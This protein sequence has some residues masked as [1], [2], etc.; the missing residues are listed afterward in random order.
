MVGRQFAL[1]DGAMLAMNLTQLCGRSPDVF[2]IPDLPAD[3]R[4]T[5]RRRKGYS[6]GARGPHA[7]GVCASV[8]DP[9]SREPDRD[10][11]VWRS[12]CRL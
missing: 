2:I 5:Y 12:A 1:N 9:L 3:F 4:N 8:H 7:T 10:R 6:A 11:A